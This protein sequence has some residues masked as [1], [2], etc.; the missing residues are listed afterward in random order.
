MACKNMTFAHDLCPGPVRV[1]KQ[2]IKWFRH[3]YRLPKDSLT[4]RSLTLG[5]NRPRGHPRKQW[6]YRISKAINSTL[7][8]AH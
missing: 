3:V 7:Y 5:Y 1:K 2:K 6:I 8:K 4:Q